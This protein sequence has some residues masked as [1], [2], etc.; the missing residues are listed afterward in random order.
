MEIYTNEQ[1]LNALKKAPRPIQR[2]FGSENTV[3]VVV[4][5]QNK[6]GLHVDT[7]GTVNNEI[8]NLLLGLIDPVAFIQRLQESGIDL[9]TANSIAQDVNTQIFVPLQKKMREAPVEDDEEEVTDWTE[10]GLTAASSLPPVSQTVATVP[11]MNIGN[12]TTSQGSLVQKADIV[13]VPQAPAPIAVTQPTQSVLTPSHPR[14]MQQDM[15]LVQQGNLHDAELG[16]SVITPTLQPPVTPYTAPARVALT[17][18]QAAVVP[19]PQYAAR[20]QA[21]ASAAY[22]PPVPPPAWHASAA[23]SFQT[24]SIPNT[25]PSSL[26]VPRYDTPVQNQQPITPEPYARVAPVSLQQ[27]TATPIK[28]E[29][30]SDPYREVPQ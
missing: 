26:N 16:A 11:M 2:A 12:A 5:I 28:K 15:Q 1:I 19:P 23:A 29:Y 9:K 3:N 4:A 30:G 10:P 17:Q 13:F 21:V 22:V 18:E 8:G 24:A 6:Y 27:P 7:I 14:T 20:P 25:A